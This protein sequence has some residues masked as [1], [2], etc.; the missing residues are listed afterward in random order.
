MKKLL[1]TIC[2]IVVLMVILLIW[3]DQSRDYYCFSDGKCFTIWTH[4]TYGCY[5]IP[6]KYRGV[7]APRDNYL[8][9]TDKSRGLGVISDRKHPDKIIVQSD[10][11]CHIVQKQPGVIVF[12]NEEEKKKDKEFDSLYTH[13][14]GDYRSYNDDLEY[15]N[16]DVQ[17]LTAETNVNHG[18]GVV[19]HVM[20]WGLWPFIVFIVCGISLFPLVVVLVFRLMDKLRRGK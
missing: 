6:G 16:V 11:S 18:V 3:Q 10:S 14:N 7:F 12:Y 2:S 20:P 4:D 1:I 17:E 13:P 19:S 5:L 9:K 15:Y 8:L